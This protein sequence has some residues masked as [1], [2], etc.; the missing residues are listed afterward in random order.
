[1]KQLSLNLRVVSSVVNFPSLV[2]YFLS[3]PVPFVTWNV[4]A[5]SA[6]SSVTPPD[7]V[8]F[9]SR[10][11]FSI[12]LSAITTTCFE[13]EELVL[14]ETLESELVTTPFLTVNFIVV[15]IKL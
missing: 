3:V 12:R 15:V 2:R 7:I 9:N 13:S 1:M 11:P 8:F 5:P 4:S 6:S 14:I 10:L